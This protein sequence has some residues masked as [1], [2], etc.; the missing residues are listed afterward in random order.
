MNERKTE[1][2]AGGVAENIKECVRDTKPGGSGLVLKGGIRE[3]YK[4]GCGRSLKVSLPLNFYATSC[5]YGPGL[6]EER[7]GVLSRGYNGAVCCMA[8][9]Q[10]DAIRALY[11]DIL[12]SGSVS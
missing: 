2:P 12:G 10:T 3:R 1:K 6:H 4:S 9:P 7:R 5:H 11:G 8:C